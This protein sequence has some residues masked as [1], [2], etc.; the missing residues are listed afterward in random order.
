MTVDQREEQE[1]IDIFTAKRD[2]AI[3]EGKDIFIFDGQEVLV[4]YA[5]YVIENHNN[6]YKGR[7]HEI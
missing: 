4:S 1:Y 5:K 3:E 2:L 6:K 7:D